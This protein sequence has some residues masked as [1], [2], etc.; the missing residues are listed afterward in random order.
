MD[1]VERLRNV[2]KVEP[3]EPLCMEAADEI[4][5]LREVIANMTEV[6][7]HLWGVG[8]TALGLHFASSGEDE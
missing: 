7:N 1:I 5:R 4:E 6:S 3:H 8:F 2:S